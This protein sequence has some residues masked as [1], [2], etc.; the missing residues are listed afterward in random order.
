[1]AKTKAKQVTPKQITHIA[2]IL[3]LFAGSIFAWYQSFKETGLFC[4]AESCAACGASSF[5][6]LPVCV[7]G[8][9]FFTLALILA[10]VLWFM[11]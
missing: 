3:V 4:G 5:L 8:A 11:E 6:G 1:M 9:L 7:M 2:L 10:A